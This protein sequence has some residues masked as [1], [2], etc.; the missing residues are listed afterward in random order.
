MTVGLDQ[1]ALVRLRVGVGGIV[2]VRDRGQAAA[3]AAAAVP[4]VLSG[5]AKGRIKPF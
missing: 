5:T 4:A 2:R 3:E 1:G